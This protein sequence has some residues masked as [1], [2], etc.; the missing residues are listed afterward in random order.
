MDWFIPKEEQELYTVYVF[1]LPFNAVYVGITCDFQRRMKEHSE[2]D[3]AVHRFCKKF[4][5]TSVPLVQNKSGF[6]ASAAQEKE[7]ELVKYFYN[8]GCMVLNDGKT[9]KCVGSLGGFGTKWSKNV[10]LNEA[11]KYKSLRDFRKK[12]DGAYQKAC[13]KKWIIEIREMYEN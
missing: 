4:N 8:K 5:I 10:V 9:G 6:T 13:K 12:A 2:Q 3:T 11:R 7:D 1:Y